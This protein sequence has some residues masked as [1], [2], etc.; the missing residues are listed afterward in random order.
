MDLGALWI[1]SFHKLLWHIHLVRTVKNAGKNTRTRFRPHSP[2]PYERRLRFVHAIIRFLWM[3][4][5][6]ICTHEVSGEKPP[7]PEGGVPKPEIGPE[8]RHPP[9][10]P[11][12]RCLW[13]GRSD[14]EAVL[15]M[16]D[17]DL[18]AHM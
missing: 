12:L 9:T 1:D 10:V 3:M 8:T 13:A 4:D 16:P 11:E 6:T 14:V 15:G 2:A 18:G 7:P 17:A 5:C